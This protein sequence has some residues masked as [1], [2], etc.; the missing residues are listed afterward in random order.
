MVGI[1]WTAQDIRA[2][3]ESLRLSPTEFARVVGVTKRT[4]LLWEQG[5]T[6]TLHA[7]SRRLLDEVLT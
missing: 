5:R 7:S 6:K 3:R 1:E 2:L 4:I